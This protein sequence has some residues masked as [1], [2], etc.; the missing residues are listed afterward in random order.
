LK[1]PLEMLTK[2]LFRTSVLLNLFLLFFSIKNTYFISHNIKWLQNG[3]WGLLTAK[4]KTTIFLTCFSE[5][6]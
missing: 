3:F 6:L 5:P 1:K 2:N 4:Q